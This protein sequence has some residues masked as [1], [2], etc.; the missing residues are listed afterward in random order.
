LLSLLAA[1]TLVLMGPLGGSQTPL[2]LTLEGTGT[3]NLSTGLYQVIL[4]DTRTA[5]INVSGGLYKYEASYV[6][7]GGDYFAVVKLWSLELS[8]LGVTVKLEQVE[9]V[10]PY[11]QDY[12]VSIKLGYR[13][14]CPSLT[15]SYVGVTMAPLPLPVKPSGNCTYT[16]TTGGVLSVSPSEWLVV[17]AHFNGRGRAFVLLGPI[18]LKTT[19]SASTPGVNATNAAKGARPTLPEPQAK[20][21]PSPGSRGAATH[22]LHLTSSIA[23]ALSLASLILALVAE[24]WSGKPV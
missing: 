17:E 9:K 15:R 12:D 21:R 14:Y 18:P 23:I 13:G 4:E 5:I 10:I 24:R 20:G 1:L 2:H 6:N 22:G 3:L 11:S 19:H 8:Q 16:V 7:A